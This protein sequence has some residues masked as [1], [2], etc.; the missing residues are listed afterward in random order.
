MSTP[1]TPP[2]W[3]LLDG[4]NIV[5]ADA[6][7]CGIDRSPAYLA[8]RLRLLDERFSPSCTISLW[9]TDAPTF[10]HE[11][12]PAYKAGRKRLDGIERAI[13]GAK[14]VCHARNIATLSAV[15]FEA[16]DLIATITAEATADGCQVLI[17]STDRDLHQLIQQGHV[18][19]CTKVRRSRG[20]LSFEMMNSASLRE[21]YGVRPEQWVDFK[22]LTGDHSDGIP[23]IPHIGAK[24]A[25]NVLESCGTLDGFYR[26]PF[27]APISP[28]QRAAII[29]A[30]PTIEPMRTLCRVRTDAPLPELW[31]EGV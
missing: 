31:K 20:V 16:D 26:Y 25:A 13:A 3:L 12:F 17:Y 5:H 2:L 27:R 19:Q 29:N 28:R 24:T 9:D 8:E 23:G 10:R 14:D 30:K 7:G 1:N 21:R 18:K 4:E 11:L 15:G 6:Y 22:V